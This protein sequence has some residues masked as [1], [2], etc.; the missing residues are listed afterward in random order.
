MPRLSLCV[1]V[2]E[3]TYDTYN[4][5]IELKGCT[6]KELIGEMLEDWSK[7]LGAAELEGEMGMIV[8]RDP[9]N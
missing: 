7:S 3:E 4:A 2:N 6:M 9:A 8:P 5:L 1:T